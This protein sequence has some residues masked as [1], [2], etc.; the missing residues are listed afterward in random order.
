MV[1][2][3]EEKN[4]DFDVQQLSVDATLVLILQLCSYE[5]VGASD[6]NETSETIIS[7]YKNGMFDIIRSTKV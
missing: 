2:F 1:T 4:L 5:D 7:N 3:W 6:L